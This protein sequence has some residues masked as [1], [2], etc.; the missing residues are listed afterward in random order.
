MRS[1]QARDHFEL[2][3]LDESLYVI[4]RKAQ[5]KACVLF[6]LIAESYECHSLLISRPSGRSRGWNDVLPD[7][8]IRA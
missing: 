5:P 6:N 7:P 2:I 3:I 4:P 8:A 1:H